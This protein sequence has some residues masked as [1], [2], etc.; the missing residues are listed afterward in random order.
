MNK[1]II[2]KNPH[3]G[4]KIFCYK[5]KRDNPICKHYD[6]QK[7]K[8]VIHVKGEVAKRKSQVLISRIYNEAVIEAIEYEKGLIAT[9]FQPIIHN[10]ENN[11]YSILGAVSVYE[12]YL[13]GE[14]RYAHMLKIVSK[15]HQSECM[16]FCDFFLD[17]IIAY[18]DIT[19]T[20][21]IDVDQSDVA[22]FYKWADGH[23]AARTFNKCLGA[24]RAFFNFLINVEAI[25]IKNPFAVYQPKAVIKKN[26]ETLTEDEFSSILS[27][28]DSAGSIKVL[29]GKGE[30]KNMFRP[31]L[32]DGFKLFLL[33]GGR[34]EEVVDLRWSN[35]ISTGNN[36][37][38]FDIENLKVN[39]IK[40]MGHSNKYNKRI[41][42]NI[43]LFDLLV[44]LG[45]EDKKN[46]NDFILFP[47]RNV[48]TETI[49]NNMSKSFTFY[50]EAA[51]IKKD[52]SL[53]NLRKTYIT[54]L[55]RAMG[56]DTGILTSHGGQQVLV[57]HYIDGTI[58]TAVEEAALEF[59]VFGT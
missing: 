3:K 24:L 17:S 45:Y 11:N 44:T 57:D 50:A 5:C 58:L 4:M 51:G 20:S 25:E 14:H 40:K 28:I 22:R 8:V 46:S 38:F 6:I 54:W 2:P 13:K 59:R 37:M 47:K 39:R 31:Y 52:V 55:N 15:S 48:K 36:V 35:I 1:L 42:V 10:E 49:M 53:N 33:T 16:K 7:Y 23:Y 56:K 41:P 12:N 27:A 21:I 30:R 9:N 34:R 18:K 26:V 32:K 29:G 43:D 19:S